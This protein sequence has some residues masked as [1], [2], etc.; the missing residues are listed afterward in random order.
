MSQSLLDIFS[1]GLRH[2]GTFLCHSGGLNG[3]GGGQFVP[4]LPIVPDHG[5]AS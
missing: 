3:K 5:D 4:T 1:G 2:L